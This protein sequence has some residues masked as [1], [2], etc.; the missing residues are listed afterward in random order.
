MITNVL[1]RLRALYEDAHRLVTRDIWLLETLRPP[2]A[3]GWQGFILRQL[4]VV[5]VVGRGFLFDHQCMTRAAALTYTTLLALVPM[6]AFMF[7]FLKGLGVQNAL[8]PLLLD[9]LPVTSEG[10][11]RQII[12]Y[13]NNVQVGTLGVLGLGSLL[14]TTILQ[15]GNVEHALNNIWGVHSGRPLL[16]KIADY[17]SIMVIGP[18][19]LVLAIGLSTALQHQSLLTTLMEQRLIGDALLFFFR[20]LRYV[21][22]WCAFAFAYAFLP[23]TQDKLLPALIGGVLGGTLWQLGLGVY[24]DVLIST[25]RFKAIYGAFAQLPILMVWIYLSWV[26]TLLGAEVTFACQ[27]A[28][29]YHL[30]RLTYSTSFYVKAWLATTLYF[31]LVRAYTAGDGPW[32]AQAFAQERGV[33]IRLLREVLNI[34]HHEHL[35]VEVSTP[36]EHYVPGRHPDTITPWDILRALGHHGD[37]SME[38]LLVR[39]DA[40]ATA[41]LDHMEGAARKTMGARSVPQWLAGSEHLTAPSYERSSS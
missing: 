17:I 31:A 22:L 21:A 2:Y 20:F 12:N 10:A 6:L 28:A 25:T 33:P 16:R 14:F 30:E 38:D 24:I 32:S 27:N 7:A 11:V 8:E 26:V 37:R 13:V 4:R 40:Q 9:R 19:V 15:F 5:L 3:T 23:N 18:L 29:T 39:H 35:I 34:L 36:P 1:A 41:L